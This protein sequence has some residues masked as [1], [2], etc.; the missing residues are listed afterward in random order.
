M[1]RGPR[2]CVVCGAAFAGSARALYCS[3]RCAKRA[4]YLRHADHY[5]A[6]AR[7]HYRPIVHPPQACAQCA[8]PFTP[9]VAG[10]RYCSPRYYLRA[11]GEH[12][13]ERLRAYTRSRSPARRLPQ[14]CTQC[15]QPFTPSRTTARYCS[16]TCRRA[17]YQRRPPRLRDAISP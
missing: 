9:A 3:R 5:R 7:Q 1:S 13:R 16:E 4:S 2:T 17:S 12:N 8:Q 11:Y 6:L 15:G 14:A 10:S